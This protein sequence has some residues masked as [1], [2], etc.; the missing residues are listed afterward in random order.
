MYAR[1]LVPLRAI[2]INTNPNCNW[3][4]DL[5]TVLGSNPGSDDT[6]VLV[7]SAG[8]NSSMALKPTHGSRCGPRSWAS[9]LLLILTGALDISAGPGCGRAIDPDMPVAT[10]Q[11]IWMPWTKVVAHVIQVCM[12][13]SATQPSCTKKTTGGGPDPG[14]QCGLG[15]QHWLHTLA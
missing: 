6:M 12:G 3:T 15:W 10:V 8:P 14:Q 2:D 13:P 9:A 4:M 1:P 11:A 5:D 7:G